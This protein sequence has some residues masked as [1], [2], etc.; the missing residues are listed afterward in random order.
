MGAYGPLIVLPRTNKESKFSN[1]SEQNDAKSKKAK[2]T[3]HLK[4]K[5][6][7]PRQI[8]HLQDHI[9]MVS[10]WYEQSSVEILTRL[11]NEFYRYG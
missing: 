1:S 10:D 6:T 5:E 7:P 3:N 8:D 2:P 11:R 4:R 9:M